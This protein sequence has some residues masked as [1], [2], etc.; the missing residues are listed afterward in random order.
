MTLLQLARSGLSFAALHSLHKLI[1]GPGQADP[2][3]EC[4][5]AQEEEANT[6]KETAECD[7]PVTG[8]LELVQPSLAMIVVVGFRPPAGKYYMA[9]EFEIHR[10]HHR[11][12]TNYG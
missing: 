5:P 2:R 3:D 9:D 1:H 4:G 12:H 10:S 7:I 11:V 8:R 6:T